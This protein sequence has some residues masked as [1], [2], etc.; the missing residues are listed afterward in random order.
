MGGCLSVAA[1]TEAA[2]EAAPAAER[3]EDTIEPQSIDLGRDNRW[4]S[5]PALTLEQLR[6]QREEFWDTAPFYEGRT[7]VWQA[8]RVACE[9]DPQLATAILTSIVTVPTGRLADG[10]YDDQGVK[11]VV[12][13]YCLSEPA[14]LRDVI[15]GRASVDST[16]SMAQTIARGKKSA[17]YSLESLDPVC[18]VS[19]RLATGK[20][21]KLMLAT[22]T[23][24]AQME[25]MMRDMQCVPD[26]QRVRFFYLGKILSPAVAPVRDMQLSKAAMLQAMHS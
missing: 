11:Y 16:K 7:E 9:S 26:D 23:T 3:A 8:L 10:V 4:H 20:D 12:P 14:N 5:E 19:V 15:A 1:N 22:D 24:V 25:Q 6:R 2:T 18:P 13:E 17:D 21:V